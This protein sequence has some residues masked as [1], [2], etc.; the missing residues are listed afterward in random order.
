MAHRE[1]GH[2][3]EAL[4]ETREV[5]ARR[6]QIFGE[7]AGMTALAREELGSALG[8]AGKHAEA[9]KARETAIADELAESGPKSVNAAQGR[10][11]LAEDYIDLG[12]YDDAL[13]TL[14]L[15]RPILVAAEGEQHPEVAIADLAIVH[16]VVLRAGKTKSMAGL[17]QARAQLDGI[18]VAFGKTFGATSQA[19]AAVHTTVGELEAVRGRW[20]AAD[21]AYAAALAALGDTTGAD[22]G[23]VLMK[24]AH[25]QWALGQRAEARASATAA[26]KDFAA[27]PDDLAEA[28]AW[29]A[30]PT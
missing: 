5:L 19:M 23:E 8:L 1:L 30:N 27:K 11:N 7:H 17:D 22:R 9:A 13:T 2:I 20:A 15:A 24:R 21:A 16:A 4:A 12:R 6:I 28:R 25:V 10:V 29:L 3:D 18:A 26:E 14:A